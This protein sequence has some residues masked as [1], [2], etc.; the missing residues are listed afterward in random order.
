M[1]TDYNKVKIK[2]EIA[3]NP[4][5]EE[6]KKRDAVVKG[7]ERKPGLFS[8]AGVL[9][10]GEDGFK[11][12]TEHL[13]RDILIQSIQTTISDVATNTINTIS[14]VA[15]TSIKRA[16]FGESYDDRRRNSNDYWYGSR[17]YVDNRMSSSRGRG[18]VDY[19]RQSDRA[20]H[21][22]SENLSNVVRVI[23]FDSAN[24]ANEVLSYMID[25]VDQYGLVTVADFYELS[26]VAS[27]F[28]DHQFGWTNLDGVRVV[29]IR[30]GGFYISF[31]PAA[32]V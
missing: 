5:S 9:F 1:S 23:E 25:S 11:G 16:I 14:D 10:F 17:R 12:V 29:P 19:S 7:R 32:T 30:G 31:P 24:D 28:T 13:V 18:Y 6:L 3:V 26:A 27:K 22:K 21:H 4:E 2:R 8:R 20:L 15:T